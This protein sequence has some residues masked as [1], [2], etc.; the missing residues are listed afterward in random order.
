MTVGFAAGVSKDPARVEELAA[1]PSALTRLL[2]SLPS[3]IVL[4][5]RTGGL[6]KRAGHLLGAAPS[7]LI[8]PL[9]LSRA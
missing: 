1:A 7:D 3:A 5:G 8:N 4:P 9:S 2:F 6:T